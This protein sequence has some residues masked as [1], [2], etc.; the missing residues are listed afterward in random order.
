[1]SG[2]NKW[3]TIKHKKART[4][5]ARGKLF[6][7]LI[8]EITVSARVGGGDPDGNPR[9][10]SAVL[11]ARKASMPNDTINRAIKRG[12]G[13]ADGD[14]YEELT[15]EGYGPHGVAFFLECLTDNRNRTVAEVRHLFSKHG[16]NLGT[17]GSVAWMFEQRGYIEIPK[18]A[19]EFDQLFEDAVEA[20]AEDIEQADEHFSVY[21]EFAS[22]NEVTTTLEAKGYEIGASKPIRIPQNTIAVS[23]GAAASTLKLMD[24]LDD[25]DD[26]QNVYMNAEIA[27][28][29]IEALT[30]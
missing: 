18:D 20:G 2:H 1:M 4:D 14:D 21:C 13:D 19:V 24:A 12:S 27:E 30:S 22:L 11:A 7:K 10:R 26:V 17:D 16:G 28:E 3:S 15:Y 29:E 8:R 6:T 23:G 5:A 9:L 25:Q